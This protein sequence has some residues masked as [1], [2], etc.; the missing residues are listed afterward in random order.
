ML[1]E[2]TKF[3]STRGS[4]PAFRPRFA[5]KCDIQSRDL[6]QL[7]SGYNFAVKPLEIMWPRNHIHNVFENWCASLG[8]EPDT[9]DVESLLAAKFYR[10]KLRYRKNQA[11]FVNL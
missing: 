3:H 5:G 11:F 9:F 4:F 7:P 8:F 10:L 6:T 2:K 1:I